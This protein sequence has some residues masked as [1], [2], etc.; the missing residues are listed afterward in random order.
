[1]FSLGT[2]FIRLK[3]FAKFANTTNATYDNVPTAYWSVL[4]A[5]VSI[6]C[7][8]LP[9]VRSLLRRVLPTC[10]GSTGDTPGPSYRISSKNGMPSSG[11][12][13]SVTNAV[14][15]QQRSTESGTFELVDKNQEQ[16]SDY[17]N[18]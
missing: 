5:F 4:E 14:S 15:F 10:F 6:I 2:F 3:S 17:R 11:I 12:K 7:S 18:W 9:A 13:K 8:C 1:M 16:N